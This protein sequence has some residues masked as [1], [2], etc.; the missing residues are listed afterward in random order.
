[1][2]R[3]RTYFR[4]HKKLVLA[5]LGVLILIIVGALIFGGNGNG[6]HE[7]ATV[8]RRTVTEEVQVSGT[9][10]ANIVSDLGFEASGVVR[11]VTVDV[12]DAVYKGQVLASL[13]L[14]TLAAELQSAQA[15]LAIKRAEVANTSISLDTIKEKHDTL[16]TNARIELYSDGLIAEPK[17]STYTQLPPTISGRYTGDAGIYK[18][19]I[20]PGS[21]SDD[22]DLYVFDMEDPDP[23]EVSRTGATPIGTKGLFVSFPTAPSQYEGTTWYITIPNEKSSLYPANYSAYQD[24]LRERDRVIEDAEAELRREQEGASIAEAQVARAQAEVARIQALIE[25][26]ILRAPFAGIITA[27]SIDPGETVS[28]SIPSISLISNDGF[29]VEIDLPEIDSIKVKNGNTATVTLDALGAEEVLHASVVSV[30]RTETLVDGIAVYEARLAFENQ[31][32][33]IA[34][35]MTAE[36]SI[37]TNKRDGV[38]ALPIRAFRFREDG[39]PYVTVLESEEEKAVEVSMGLRG[40]DGY[41]EIMAGLVEGQDVIIPE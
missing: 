4:A 7:I 21:Q 39:T 23:V 15:D 20:R 11:S 33:R 19:T 1:M 26:R 35:G 3:I 41:V 16:V 37:T 13:G 32:D 31:D 38:L 12:N 24:A 10:E 25:E 8:E 34:S 6:D 9:V 5:L 29:G 17:S 14:G 2:Q 27:V 22:S 40:S 36:V 28:A 18:I 30:N